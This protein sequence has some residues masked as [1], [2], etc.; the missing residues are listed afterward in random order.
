MEPKI[1]FYNQPNGKS[2]G[3]LIKELAE[4]A[5]RISIA[6]AFLTE[7]GLTWLESF[8]GASIRVMCGISACISDLPFLMKWVQ[9]DRV[10]REG[11]IF[12]GEKMFH[13]K[14]FIFKTDLDVNILMGSA[15]FTERGTRHNEEIM[16]RISGQ[17]TDETIA[18]IKQYFETMWNTRSDTVEAYLDDHK[19]YKKKSDF[20]Q[21][22]PEQVQ[23]L[24]RLAL[25]RFSTDC[26]FKNRVNKTSIQ[27]G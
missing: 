2:I 25:K 4:K 26:E 14:L 20:E 15:N 16:I 8:S 17:M 21:L 3:S 23:A 19:D 18:S 12:V 5:E 9:E 10:T 22:A 11:R 7:E 6:T 13:P 1:R 24:R 27:H